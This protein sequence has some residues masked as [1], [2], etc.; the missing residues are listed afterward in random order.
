VSDLQVRD[1]V[2]IALPRGRD[3]AVSMSEMA[4]KLSLGRRQVELAIQ[5][6][7]LDGI[8][9]ASGSDGVWIGDVNDMA[10]TAHILRGRLISQYRTL[11]AV[12]G[13]TARLRAAQ[14]QQTSIPWS[15]S[16]AA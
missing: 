3:N 5:A 1:L 16:D 7:R 9:V 6:L 15:V 12:R 10:A 8:P 4:E 2:H 11:R 13:T 14:Y